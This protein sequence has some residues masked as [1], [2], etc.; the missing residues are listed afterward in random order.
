MEAD[1]I[2][3]ES[4]TLVSALVSYKKAWYRETFLNTIQSQLMNKQGK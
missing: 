2:P 4:L 3:A 1:S